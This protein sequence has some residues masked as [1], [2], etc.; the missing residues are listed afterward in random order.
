MGLVNFGNGIQMQHENLALISDTT[1]FLARCEAKKIGIEECTDF[2]EWLAQSDQ[3]SVEVA[4]K[5]LKQCPEADHL[6]QKINQV[7]RICVVSLPSSIVPTGRSLLAMNTILIGNNQSEEDQLYWLLFEIQNFSQ[8]EKFEK[9]AEEALNGKV[10][11]E[12]YTRQVE[13]IEFE[14]GVAGYELNNHCIKKS[15]WKLKN[16]AAFLL[17]E[18][19]KQIGFDAFWSLLAKESAHANKIR[20]QWDLIFKSIYCKKH[21]KDKDCL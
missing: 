13:Q 3:K 9:L 1:E 20:S 2:R 16:P 21:P 17:D 15:F 11:R 14:A 7:Q 18:I 5:T 4:L 8:K 10:A 6:W 19:S 12:L